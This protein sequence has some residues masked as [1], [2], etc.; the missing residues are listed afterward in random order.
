MHGRQIVKRRFCPNEGWR[1][2]P[3]H[4]EDGAQRGALHGQP[5]GH[6]RPDASAVLEIVQSGLVSR[7]TFQIMPEFIEGETLGLKLAPSHAA[8]QRSC[9]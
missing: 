5:R 7:S 1:S 2:R 9:G 4:G 8:E 6:G 3:I